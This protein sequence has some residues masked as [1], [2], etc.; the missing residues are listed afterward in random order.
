MVIT[1]HNAEVAARFAVTAKKFCSIVDSASDIERTEFVAQVYRILP[2]LIDVAIEMPDVERPDTRQQR[3]P[4]DVRHHEWERRYNAL[5]E[6]FGDWNV[7]RQVFDPTKDS[8]AISGSLADDIADIYRDLKKG[9]ELKETY[10]RQPEAAIWQWRFGFYSHW[11]KHAMDALL[12][13]HS[14]LQK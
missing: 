11:G 6:K 14:R 9:L 4:L 10:P 3:S 8:E 1:N 7:Y 13:I 12:A 5:K 2:K